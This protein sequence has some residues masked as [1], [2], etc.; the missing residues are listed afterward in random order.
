MYFSILDEHKINKNPKETNMGREYWWETSKY[1]GST[2]D[3]Q[4]V[5][6]AP[7][8]LLWLSSRKKLFA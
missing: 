5:A 2:G 7:P 4:A 8:V 3:K 1:P 6:R